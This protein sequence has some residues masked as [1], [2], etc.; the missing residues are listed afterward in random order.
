MGILRFHGISIVGWK[1]Y[2]DKGTW[3]YN[4]VKAGYKYNMTDIQVALGPAQ[5]RK[6]E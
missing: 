6:L 5:F 4:V 2:K 3:Y 1:R